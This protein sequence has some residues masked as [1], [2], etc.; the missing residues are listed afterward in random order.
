M[1]VKLSV[2]ILVLYMIYRTKQAK[3]KI[4]QESSQ[5]VFKPITTKLDDV[6]TGI[7]IEEAGRPS[8]LGRWISMR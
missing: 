3:D 4:S 1:L 2:F 5:K 7:L 8:G 6:A